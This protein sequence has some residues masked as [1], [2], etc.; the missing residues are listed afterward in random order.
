VNNVS[1]NN[2]GLGSGDEKTTLTSHTGT[3]EGACHRV[4]SM[5][6]EW[7][8][9][10]H[11]LSLEEK[12]VLLAELLRQKTSASASVY[13]LSWGQQALWF[14]YQLAPE[15]AA[16]N[17]AYAA[18]VRSDLDILALKRAF[19]ALIERHSS[20]RTTY[21]TRDGKPV[22]QIHAHQK[23]D[24]KVTDASNWSDELLHERLAEEADR[25]FDL[26]RG[27]VIRVSLFTCPGNQYVLSLVTHHM[28]SDFWSFVV[29]INELHLVYFT[30][31]AG[32]PAALPPL[33][34]RYTD[35]I[36]WQTEM[37]ASPEGNRLWT[38]WQKQ[39]A[40][41]LPVLNLP[42]DR[43]R[44]PV[45]TDHGASHTFKLNPEI[46][47]QLKVLAKAEGATLFMTLLA[48]F[49]VLLYRY[50]NQEDILVGSPTAGRSRADFAG[51]VGYCV[52]PVVLRAD[53][54]RNPTFKE[55]LRQ[56][57]LTV[58]GAIAHQDYPFPLLVERLCPTRDPSFSPLFQ[59]MFV[60][61]KPH[62][63][64]GELQLNLGNQ[65]K[66]ELET[67]VLGSRGAAFDLTLTIFETGEPLSASWQYNTDLFDAATI[68]RMAEHFQNLL[69]GI[70][71]H[72]EQR[73]Q[74][75]PLLSTT[76]QQKLLGEWNNT[77]E[78]YPKNVCIH[79][80]FE[81]QV[82]QTPD[83]VAV[84]FADQ[85]LT[86][87]QLNRRA[88]QVAHHLRSL[89]VVADSLV[90]L[91]VERSLEM[92]VGLLGI[93]K[94]GGT[95]V[96]LDPAY[97]QSRLAFM[98]EDSQVPVLL[99]QQ[100]L[101]EK[102]PVQPAR[103]VCL[104]TDWQALAQESEA[105]P[106]GEVTANNLA[107]IIYTSGSTGRPKGVMLAH[108]GLCNLALAQQRIFH[109]QPNNRVLQFA[110]LSFDASIW[111]IVM[112][113]LAGATLVLAKREDLLPG[114]SLIQLLRDQAITT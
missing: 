40:G 24:I 68:A 13:S 104:D 67:L 92:I 27:P 100:H 109:V 95:Y 33:A 12:R 97:P 43:P 102:L 110:S 28:S 21:T 7:V 83:A 22:Q 93:L 94:A 81:A 75:L 60:W 98:L 35:Y 31:K 62:Q 37:L 44:P 77:L 30:E 89:G 106:I 41:S 69:E 1:K 17:L 64:Q 54:S 101:L 5:H 52:N 88:N 99:T 45:Q 61:D 87:Q 34:Q 9:P 14:L 32:L 16:Y 11:K 85:Q 58:L 49:Q 65:Q 82:E 56:V 112:A 2:Q 25:P 78:D 73:L 42:S 111:E 46:T 72:P 48:A 80:L 70:V 39:L 10:N 55:F 84:V 3:E 66:L 86:Y 47:Q 18:Y 59:V 90:G 57:R 63:S 26:E 108:S 79:Q 36:R 15:N 8:S 6:Q 53:L 113:L 71:T 38:Y 96:P 19:E 51:I 103:V 4:E 105:N 114:P 76:E 23:V 107:Y 29:L 50:T 20:L 91:C 74:D